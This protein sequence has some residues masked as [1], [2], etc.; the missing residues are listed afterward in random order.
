MQISW[1]IE[2]EKQLSRNIAQIG[3]EIKDWKPVFQKAAENLKE[4]FSEDVFRTQGAVIGERWNP[5]K[6]K[7]LAQKLKDGFPAD[8]LVKTGKMKD[9]FQ[10]LVKSDYAEIWNS[11]QYFKYHQSRESRNKLPRR[12][13]MKLGNSQKEMI[14]KLFHTYWYKKTRT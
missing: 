14:V 3:K 7:Y 13:M 4:V 1:S 2:G 8:P 11:T 10:F 5:L 12:V 6:P 9:N